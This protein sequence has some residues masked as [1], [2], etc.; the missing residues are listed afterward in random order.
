MTSVHKAEIQLPLNR[1]PENILGGER[2]GGERECAFI[3]GE[4][5]GNLRAFASTEIL[6]CWLRNFLLLSPSYS[7]VVPI[8]SRCFS[9]LVQLPS[10]S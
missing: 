3:I 7:F 4:G 2:G 1:L 8:F 10:T 5:E 9:S 6:C